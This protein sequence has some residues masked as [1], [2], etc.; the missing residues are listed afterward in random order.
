VARVSPH[1]TLRAGS[2]ATLAVDTEALHFFDSD[3]GQAIWA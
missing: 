1:S 2:H 3:T